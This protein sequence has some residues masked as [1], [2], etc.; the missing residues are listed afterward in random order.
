MADKTGAEDRGDDAVLEAVFAA[1]RM[2]P[3]EPS[4]GLLERVLAA[5][6]VMPARP[7][8]QVRG[9]RV[10]LW[11]RLIEMLGGWGGLGGLATATIAGVWIGYYGSAD[12]N[13]LS[14]G[15]LGTETIGSVELMPGADVF[16]Q[17][18][19]E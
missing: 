16:A 18:T 5:S 17:A 19:G 7:P 9:P 11:D 8:I 3:P 12:V 1:A 4:E 13:T 2:A 14:G 6:D 10:G 15:L